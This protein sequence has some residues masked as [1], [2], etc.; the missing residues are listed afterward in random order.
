MRQFWAVLNQNP[1]FTLEGLVGLQLTRSRAWGAR[2][3]PPSLAAASK[4]VEELCVLS[5]L[6][7]EEIDR[8]LARAGSFLL[9]MFDEICTDLPQ[10]QLLA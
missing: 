9:V 4:R 5:V 7:L 2:L 3:V 8:R 10:S 6:I 1:P